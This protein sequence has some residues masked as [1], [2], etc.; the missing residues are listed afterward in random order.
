MTAA[1]SAEYSLSRSSVGCSA[2]SSDSEQPVHSGKW[3]QITD[4][5]LALPIAAATPAS[6]TRGKPRVAQNCRNSRRGRS[7]RCLTSRQD[8]RL[9]S[10]IGIQS[11][12]SLLLVLAGL[13][14]VYVMQKA[15]FTQLQE[16]CR[17][18]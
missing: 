2:R 9:R 11:P 16:F 15:I 1:A 10:N 8:S 14:W 12:I 17:S 6:A 7:S 4:G 3:S 18:R 13:L 5:R